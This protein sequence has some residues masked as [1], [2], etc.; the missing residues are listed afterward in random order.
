M[1][2][3]AVMSNRGIAISAMG[4][5][6]GGAV[7]VAKIVRSIGVLKVV[8]VPK[9]EPAQAGSGWIQCQKGVERVMME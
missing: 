8:T 5:S 7:G 1:T 4:A 9:A 3:G 2:T 6:L